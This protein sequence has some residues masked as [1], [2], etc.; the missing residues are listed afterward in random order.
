MGV[1]VK[2]AVSP[3]LFPALRRLGEIEVAPRLLVAGSH[4]GQTFIVLER[5]EGTYP[6]KLWFGSHLPELARF[7]K[8]YQSDK[9]LTELLKVDHSPGKQQ[10]SRRIEHLAR[11][12]EGA[13]HARFE[14]DE[15]LGAMDTFIEQGACLYEPFP[16]PT[17]ADPNYKNILLTSG[18][19]YMVDW[20]G[21][22]LADPMRDISLLLWW[23]VPKRDWTSFFEVYSPDAV[24][25]D[26]LAARLYWW[27]ACRSL[28]VAL[29]F[30]ERGDEGKVQMFLTDFLAA[31]S[32]GD[33]PQL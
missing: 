18:R 21:L 13:T 6:K 10:I 29:W 30:D 15:V 27:V 20:D 4:D 25:A 5:I 2:L 24:D 16:V 31:V 7:V 17:H 33:N 32:R 14:S 26:G 23:Y 8:A 11:R 1:F 22:A 9:E 28:S 3:R 19:L 12:L